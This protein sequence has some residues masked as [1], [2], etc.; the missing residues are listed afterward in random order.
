MGQNAVDFPK[1]VANDRYKVIG[2]DKADHAPDF[3]KPV[4]VNGGDIEII[5]GL[6]ASGLTLNGL[7]EGATV[8]KVGL[9]V[10]H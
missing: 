7:F 6:V 10:G 9:G 5:G 3:C 2:R 4:D 8:W 1:A